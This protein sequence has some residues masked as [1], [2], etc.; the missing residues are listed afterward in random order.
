MS[1]HK[2]NTGWDVPPQTEHRV[3]YPTANRKQGG[4]SHH[5]QKTGWDIP[6]ETENRVGGP[7]GNRTSTYNEIPRGGLSE[8]LWTM[9]NNA[10]MGP[11]KRFFPGAGAR[12]PGSKMGKWDIPSNFSGPPVA[13]GISHKKTGWDSP[14][15]Y[16]WIWL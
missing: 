14:L 12:G 16:T 13:G 10:E 15:W 2:Q 4:M 11:K 7:T 1:H 6:P 3:G 9:E 8:S 5:K